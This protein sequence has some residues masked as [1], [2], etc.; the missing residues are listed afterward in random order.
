MALMKK[1]FDIYKSIFPLRLTFVRETASLTQNELAKLLG[2]KQ[3]TLSNWES[4]RQEPSFKKLFKL[5]VILKVSMDYLLG[6]DT[7]TLTIFEENKSLIIENIKKSTAK[8]ETY[9]KLSN[10][11]REANKQFRRIEKEGKDRHLD[12]AIDKLLIANYELNLFLFE[13]DLA[14]F[15]KIEPD[16]KHDAPYINIFTKFHVDFLRNNTK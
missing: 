4:G 12:K 7:K 13:S 11:V 2:I 16:H 15:V 3:S 14:R 5:S 6:H 10:N 1:N 8:I 9:L